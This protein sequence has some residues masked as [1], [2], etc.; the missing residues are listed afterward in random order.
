M[1]QYFVTQTWPYHRLLLYEHDRE[2]QANQDKFVNHF[3]YKP[4]DQNVVLIQYYVFLYSFLNNITRYRLKITLNLEKCKASW[5]SLSQ[6]FQKK[7]SECIKILV[8]LLMIRYY[9]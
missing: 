4:D 3:I 7:C 8:L 1:I 2:A 9:T 5:K 6:V